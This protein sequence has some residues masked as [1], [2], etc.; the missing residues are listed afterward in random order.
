MKRQQK[1]TFAEMRAS[2]V[3]DVL[4]YYPNTSCSH[5]IAELDPIIL[6]CGGRRRFGGPTPTY[7]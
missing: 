6:L 1:I 7:S 2:G 4:I 3:C 5:Y